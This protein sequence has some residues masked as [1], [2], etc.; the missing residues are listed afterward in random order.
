MGLA[1]VYENSM[2]NNKPSYDSDSDLESQKSVNL[3]E[4]HKGSV[5]DAEPCGPLH[6][7]Q[8]QNHLDCSAALSPLLSSVLSISKQEALPFQ[9]L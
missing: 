5:A 8:M 2:E 4:K 6:Y 9:M 7:S 3:S 1:S